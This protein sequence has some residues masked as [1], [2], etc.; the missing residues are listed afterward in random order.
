MLPKITAA[1]FG[2]YRSAILKFPQRDFENTAAVIFNA[3][4]AICNTLII[5]NLQ[6]RSK[7]TE[8]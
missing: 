6:N 4:G 8:L 7:I 5:N 1:L 3:S 2:N